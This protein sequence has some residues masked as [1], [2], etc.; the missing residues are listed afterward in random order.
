MTLPPT[1]YPQLRLLT[2]YVMDMPTAP[3]S[4]TRFPDPVTRVRLD[5]TGNFYWPLARTSFS[6]TSPPPHSHNQI[7][8]QTDVGLIKSWTS[9]SVKDKQ[10]GARDTLEIG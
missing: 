7:S 10:A 5:F 9:C 4:G 6:P 3:E 8:F 1:P 2:A